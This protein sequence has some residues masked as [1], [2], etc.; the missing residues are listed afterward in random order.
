MEKA[1]TVDFA[2]FVFTPDDLATIRD[3]KKL[4]VRDNVLFE[5][6][7][8]IG[9]LGK[10]RCF[11]VKPRDAE[12]HFPTDL[13]G[14]TPA[15]YDGNRSDSDLASAVNHPCVLIKKEVADLGLI[16]QDL[17]IQKNRRKKSGYR[18]KLGEVEHRLLVKILENYA[19]AA[20]GVSV[21]RTF[22]ELNIDRGILA[23]ASIKL[24]RLGYIEKGI[25]ID[26][27]HEFYTFAINADGIDYL[28]ENEHL[29]DSAKTESATQSKQDFD[30]DLPF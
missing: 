5:L 4:I 11:I 1:E 6:G 24:E 28:L 9:T 29:I 23:L 2:I 10:Q 21:W 18:Y 27:D 3:Q 17:D 13:L 26:R 22:D 16:S 12:L 15:D 30:D 14:L 20:N 19:H 25:D 8:F 7:L